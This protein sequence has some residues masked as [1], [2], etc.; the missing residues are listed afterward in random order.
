MTNLELSAPAACPGGVAS[1]SSALILS[2]L[3]L[4]CVA[5]SEMIDD[6]I[7]GPRNMLLCQFALAAAIADAARSPIIDLADKI[8]VFSQCDPVFFREPVAFPH[9]LLGK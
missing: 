8:V 5:G 1:W 7:S 3:C 4:A 9:F 6:N 2:I